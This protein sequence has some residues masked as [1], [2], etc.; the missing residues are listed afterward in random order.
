MT[1]IRRISTEKLS[2]MLH[3]PLEATTELV[4][5]NDETELLIEE[6]HKYYEDALRNIAEIH[7]E[8]TSDQ[9]RQIEGWR[10]R[11]GLTC[12]IL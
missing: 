2:R 11:Y 12:P 4:Y 3:D 5:L 6:I 7:R 10:S 9:I 1:K 8:I